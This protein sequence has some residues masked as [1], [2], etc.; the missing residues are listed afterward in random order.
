MEYYNLLCFQRRDVSE[1]IASLSP[2]A[3]ISV[4]KRIATIYISA[5]VAD[6]LEN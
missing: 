6:T 5:K 3:V 4:S 1:V 2:L